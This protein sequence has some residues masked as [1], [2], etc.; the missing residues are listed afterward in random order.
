M[1]TTH[2]RI[3]RLLSLAGLYGLLSACA[4]TPQMTQLDEPA[5]LTPAGFAHKDLVEL[6]DPL[7]PII[8]SVYN[9]RDQTGQYKYH[10][11]A[12]SFSSAVTQGATSI[13]LKT[14]SESKWFIPVEREGLQNLLTE[15]KIIRAAHRSQLK[16][17]HK[18]EDAAEAGPP[19]LLYSRI[20]L[21]GGI[22]GYESNILTGGAGARYFGAGVSGEY[23]ADQVTIYLRAVDINTGRILKSVSTT[24]SIYSKEVRTGLYR[25]VRYK[26][27][28]E[29]EAGYTTNEPAQ[30]CITEAIEK[31]VVSLIIEGIADHTWALSNSSDINAEVIQRYLSEKEGVMSDAQTHAIVSENKQNVD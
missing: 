24:K 29:L 20:M 25:F 7:R 19:P 31:A 4:V 1:N 5:I 14:L 13:L 9:F 12:S 17:K 15:R 27:L 30:L 16:K 21:E 18:D 2:K 26:R 11:S 23:R 28:L 10:P 22:I 8:V 3:T 6:P